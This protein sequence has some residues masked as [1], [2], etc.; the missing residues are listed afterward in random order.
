[1]KRYILCFPAFIFLLTIIFSMN[2]F[3]AE[4]ETV[5]DSDYYMQSVL[6]SADHKT[7]EA[8]D[9]IGLSTFSPDEIF[10]LSFEKIGEY[11]S[12]TF[13]EK[14]KG[15]LSDMM[16]V[17]CMIVVLISAKAYF[18]HDNGRYINLFGVSL[19]VAAGVSSLES[20]INMLLN[21]VDVAGTFIHS[22]APVYTLLLSLSGNGASA[23]TYNSL[24]F[25]FAQI[26]TLFT[27]SVLVKLLGAYLSVSVAFSLNTLTNLNRF[28]SLVNKA[29]NTAVGFIS[30]TF[31]ALLTVRGAFSAAADT[32]SAKS[33]RFII[34]NLIPVV[35]S[36]IS[37]AYS[38]LMGSI[39]VI[40]G[41]VAAVG[42]LVIVIIV[43]PPV[44]EGA[45]C[46][47]FFSFLSYVCEMAELNEVSAVLRA[48]SS[49][50]RILIMLNF[51]LMFMLI[52]STAI[53]LS[54]KGGV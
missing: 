37:D 36:S 23:L 50:V 18:I 1:M 44:I 34:S 29:V 43:L 39:N 51:L 30:S 40:K 45:V 32:V 47:L 17:L 20:V 9:E 35:G 52:I 27:D 8:L 49:A 5:T 46:C 41:S 22:Y 19:V 2:V 42:I 25:T 28:V 6:S 10:S 33:I 53:M 48:L 13:I 12:R 16:L 38:T 14:V 11:F 24:I 3:A 15:T 31:A 21:T 54:A 26:I 7:L 4:E